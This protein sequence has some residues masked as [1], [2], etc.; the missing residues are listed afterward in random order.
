MQVWQTVAS[1]D[2]WI[3]GKW[4]YNIVF[5][6]VTSRCVELVSQVCTYRK[7]SLMFAYIPVNLI[8]L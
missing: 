3:D 4:N 2:R 6:T 7:S 8:Y 5:M 1:A